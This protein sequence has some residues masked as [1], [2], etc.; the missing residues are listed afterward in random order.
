MGEDQSGTGR[1][2][3]TVAEAAELLGL[4]V[5]AVRG[6]IKRGKLEHTKEDGTVY[7][8]LDT[9]QS[10]TRQTGQQPADD[11]PIDR[12]S[13]QVELVE[14]LREQVAYMR[15]QLA[16]EREARRRADT[17]IAQLTQAN[18][19]LAARVPE[20]EGPREEPEATETVEEEPEG[21]ESRSATVEAQEELGAERARREMAESTLHEG[22]TEER[23]RREEAERERDDLRRE[24]YARRE[25]R[26]SSET[27][28]GASEGVELEPTSYAVEVPE[29]TR[30][31]TEAAEA[32]DEQQ[33]RGRPH[34]DAPGA[35]GPQ[36]RPWWRR[37]FRN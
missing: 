33:G 28:E 1:R 13:A 16:E 8:I 3:V 10:S 9:D 7:V 24:L 32:S 20:L 27:V 14:A 23:R 5:E 34:P 19:A 25:P 35:H 17:I 2:R 18:A 30:E 12:S 11:Q 36:R 21:A 29:S 37:M 6:R 26:E 4:T 22:M 15:E 31:A